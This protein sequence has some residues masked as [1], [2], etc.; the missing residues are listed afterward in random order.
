M[1]DTI[2]QLAAE[3]AEQVIAG[4]AHL[5]LKSDSLLAPIAGEVVK[6]V[7]VAE[8][9]AIEPEPSLESLVGGV[10]RHFYQQSPNPFASFEEADLLGNPVELGTEGVV[11]DLQ[12]IAANIVSTVRDRII[13]A[14]NSIF[15]KAYEATQEHVD[16]GGVLITI[17]TDGSD[18]ELWQN[19]ALLEIIEGYSATGTLEGTHLS[20]ITF[21]ELSTETLIGHIH[22]VNNVINAQLDNILAGDM[23]EKVSNVY[24]ELF[25]TGLP[26][27]PVQCPRI[28][29][30]LGMLL[31]IALREN[32]PDGVTGS[33]EVA[34]YRTAMDKVIASCAVH[35]KR[36]IDYIANLAKS[37]RLIVEFPAPGAE[38]RQGESIIVN[39]L[40]YEGWLEAGGSVDAILGAYVSPDQPRNA[41]LIMDSKD[42]LE[43]I[44]VR[45]VGL[46]QARVRDD[47]ER[48]F[49]NDLRREIFAY[50]EE[51]GM[52]VD[53]EGINKMYERTSSIDPDNAYAFTR[54]IVIATLFGGGD[55]LQILENIDSLSERLPGI[56]L[57]DAIDL[58]IVDWLVDWALSMTK[59]SRG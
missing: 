14:V 11:A 2:N 36:Q 24:N 4:G 18:S 6:A 9:T 51:A 37:N 57:T 17:K 52:K 28:K 48:V 45:R 56:E 32:I 39:G 50:A 23:A 40:L 30:L 38:L 42:Q 58:A 1:T 43:R 20:G 44:W 31:G 47:F 54:R 49:A 13:P 19:P 34:H 15:E 41:N 5:T 33:G 55:Y 16:A 53:Q 8:A 7:D 35:V 22:S 10:N 59:V 46:L 26:F 12:P 27:A 25:N 3:V 21:P 29:H